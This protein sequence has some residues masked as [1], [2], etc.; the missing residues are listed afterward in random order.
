MWTL[1]LLLLAICLGGP[2]IA[3]KLVPVIDTK[4]TPVLLG[5][6]DQGWSLQLHDPN[7]A[8]IKCVQTIGDVVE[9][10]WDCDGTTISTMLYT[11]SNDQDNTFQRYLRLKFLQPSAV[12]HQGQLRAAHNNIDAGAISLARTTDDTEYT[13]CVYLEG[14]NFAPLYATVLQQLSNEANQ[15]PKPEAQTAA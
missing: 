7:D 8:P 3:A 2:V 4:P 13:L 6:E 1:T 11:G 15:H 9:K 14:N 10:Q 12:E 5:S